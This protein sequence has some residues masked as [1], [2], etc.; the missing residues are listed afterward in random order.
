MDDTTQT[1]KDA[2]HVMV[3][4]ITSSMTHV[5]FLTT[6]AFGSVGRRQFANRVPFTAHRPVFIAHHDASS[7][8]YMWARLHNTHTHITFCVISVGIVKWRANRTQGTPCKRES[9]LRD[10]QSQSVGNLWDYA[11][12]CRLSAG[13]LA[14][15]LTSGVVVHVKKRWRYCQGYSSSYNNLESSAK[16]ETSNTASQVH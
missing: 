1:L 14:A 13:P 2:F 8:Y 12:A 16:S 4:S 6:V 7:I 10:T 5:V 11:E 15:M 3:S 9:N